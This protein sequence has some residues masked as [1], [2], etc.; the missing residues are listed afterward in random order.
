MIS[1]NISCVAFNC[2]NNIVKYRISYML[3]EKGKKKCLLF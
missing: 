1:S 3:N 2:C